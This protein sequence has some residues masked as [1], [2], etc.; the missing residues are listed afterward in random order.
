M[1]LASPEYPLLSRPLRGPGQ[2]RRGVPEPPGGFIVFRVRAR[3]GETA[4][5]EISAADAGNLGRGRQIDQR[6]RTLLGR[7]GEQLGETDRIGQQPPALVAIA[8]RHETRMEAVDGH[9]PTGPTA[10]ELARPHDVVELRSAIGP[11]PLL[12]LR[13]ARV[14]PL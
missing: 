11:P 3:P 2:S 4:F 10:G 13:G 14:V 5:H 1:R 12:A 9:P 7:D 6:P 8:G